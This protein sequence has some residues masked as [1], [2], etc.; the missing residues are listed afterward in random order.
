MSLTK[1]FKYI[2]DFTKSCSNE[3]EPGCYHEW[4]TPEVARGA[5]RLAEVGIREEFERNRLEH[6]DNITEEQY[7][8]EKDFVSNHIDKYH[9]IP[10]MLDAIEYG[11]E[12]KKDEIIEKTCEWLCGFME[13]SPLFEYECSEEEIK[14][15]L[16]QF[17][18][19]INGE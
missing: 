8:L 1:A 9:R 5:V 2:A 13:Y 18:N 6:C 7:N 14:K 19:H 12:L 10:T 16:T 4:V 3:M 17:K 11:M 15:T